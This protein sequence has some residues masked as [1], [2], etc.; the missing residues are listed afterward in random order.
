M[1][2]E[3][4]VVFLNKTIREEH[5]MPL[6][7]GNDKLVD[8]GIDSFGVVMVLLALEDKY[9]IYTK[10]ELK[11]VIVEELTLDDIVNRVLDEVK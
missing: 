4:I 8:T 7:N 11:A 10:D 5:G 6:V 9:G 3:D 1:N 2:R